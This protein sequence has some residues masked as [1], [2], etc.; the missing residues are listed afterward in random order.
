MLKRD[1]VETEYYPLYNR[2]Y[3]MG[4]TIW[5]PLASGILTCKY[6]EGIPKGSRLMQNGYEFLVEKLKS[7]NEDGIIE[8]IS[9]LN[10]YANSKFGC[11]LTKLALA[12][13]LKNKNVSTVLLGIT[14]S[15]QLLENIDCLNLV[16]KLTS[17]HMEEIE[18]ILENKPEPYF[19]YGGEGM[20]KIDTI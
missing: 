9:N 8:K 13:C 15:E 14:N 19:G 16:E 2:P 7:L 4:T 5:S 1:R 10:R 6:N 3:E 20:R 18:K 17:K 12:W 11:N